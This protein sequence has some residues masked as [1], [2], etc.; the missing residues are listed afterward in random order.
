MYLN[1]QRNFNELLRF[2]DEHGHCN[3]PQKYR[4]PGSQGPSLGVWLDGQRRD[5]RRGKLRESRYR[6]LQALVDE[7]KLRWSLKNME[8]RRLSVAHARTCLLN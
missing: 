4:V 7:G 5:R 6:L 2:G 3:V 8:V 1:W